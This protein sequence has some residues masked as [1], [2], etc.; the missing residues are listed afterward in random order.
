MNRSWFGLLAIG[1]SGSQCSNP[2][3]GVRAPGRPSGAP[4]GGMHIAAS[5]GTVG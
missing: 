2:H 3:S 4:I 1:V 5:I